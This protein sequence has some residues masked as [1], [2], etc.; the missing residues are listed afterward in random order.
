[1]NFAQST[2]ES[3]SSDLAP[4]HILQNAN[5]NR[6]TWQ[7]QAQPALLV[8][9]PSDPFLTGI[10]I[11][12]DLGPCCSSNSTRTIILWSIFAMNGPCAPTTLGTEAWW[13]IDVVAY[14]R[15]SPL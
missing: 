8:S 5:I 7:V 12:R 13:N 3:L 4:R 10:Q 2:L 14:P 9:R 6:V 11:H 1:M 15:F